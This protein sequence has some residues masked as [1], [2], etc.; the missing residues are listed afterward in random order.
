MVELKFRVRRGNR[1]ALPDLTEGELGFALDTREL[2]IGTETADNVQ[3][4]TSAE[5]DAKLAGGIASHKAEAAAHAVSQIT[6]AETA[7]G[8][9]AKVDA[10]AGAAQAHAVTQ[11]S[12]AETPAGAQ[13]KVS[14]HA[15]A[16]PAHDVSQITGA[17]SQTALT[18]YYT[19]AQS[20]A[21]YMPGGMPPLV[22]AIIFGG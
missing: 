6:G 7:A 5:I 14:V 13:G 3:V 1:A 12:G 17:V 15:A 21:A 4:G 19:K 11:I 9:Q 22:A 2:F 10:H 16:T 18:A 8:A 20:D